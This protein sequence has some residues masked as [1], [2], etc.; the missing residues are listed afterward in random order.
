MEVL[1][2]ERPLTLLADIR[3]GREPSRRD[4]FQDAG[5]GG[6]GGGGVE[7]TLATTCIT[8]AT[9]NYSMCPCSQTC[10]HRQL[11]YK[12]LSL[13]ELSQLNSKWL[14]GNTWTLRYCLTRI[15]YMLN[16]LPGMTLKQQQP[17][18]EV[19]IPKKTLVMHLSDQVNKQIRQ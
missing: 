1:G 15:F 11:S 10:H 5:S 8:F 12:C 16:S 6:A 4:L 9:T 13:Q 3:D 2:I 17:V 18:I 14:Q 19:K 7:L